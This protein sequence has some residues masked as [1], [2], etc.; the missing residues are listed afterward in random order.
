QAVDHDSL[1]HHRLELVVDEIHA[2]RAAGGKFFDCDVGDFGGMV[3]R[4]S[5]ENPH[6]LVAN[7]ESAPAEEVASLA[8]DESKRYLTP[9]RLV[10]D[11]L[12]RRLDH[13]RVEAAAESAV[14]RDDDQQPR[15]RALIGKA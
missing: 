4:Q 10:D 12:A 15:A 2:R 9:A 13:I 14:T 5:L 1:R 3:E 8:A 11:D 7:F 6:C